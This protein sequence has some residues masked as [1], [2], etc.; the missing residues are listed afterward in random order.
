MKNVFAA[1][2]IS[3][4]LAASAQNWVSSDGTPWRATSGDCWRNSFW[5]PE[6]ASKGCD[7]AVVVAPAPQPAPTPV[8]Q[9]A[10]APMPA[11]APIAQPTPAPKPAPAPA[12]VAQ[13]T[14]APAPV[15]VAPV[16][17][18]TPA[19]KPQP[20]VL[21]L[22]ANTLFDSGKS[23]LKPAGKEAI[24]GMVD[25]LKQTNLKEVVVYGHSD[26]TG[27]K[28]ANLR[29][30]QRRAQSVVDYLVAMGIPSSVIRA[31]GKGIAEPVATNKTAAGRAQNRR[32]EI[33]VTAVAPAK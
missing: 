12:P 21:K 11:P 15:V 8:A 14:P 33:S 7:G 3:A 23:N 29:L 9:P 26:S 25:E 1:T 22:D 18:P 2:L 5:T 20:K 4:S 31:E 16:A 24:N 10:P 28:Q 32:V 27:S 13:P 19:P 17:Q 30:S 6:N